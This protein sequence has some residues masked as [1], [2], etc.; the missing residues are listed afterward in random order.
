MKTSP[1]VTK[2]LILRLE[3]RLYEGRYSKDNKRKVSVCH[4]RE[5]R[6]SM[7]GNIGLYN[8]EPWELSGYDIP[9][10]RMLVL[11]IPDIFLYKTPES[12]AEFPP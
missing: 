11:Y 6:L 4:L 1:L 12:S 10:A 7:E 5:P 2:E 3:G 8:P 9:G